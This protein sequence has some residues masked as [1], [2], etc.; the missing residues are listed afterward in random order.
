[1]KDFVCIVILIICGFI[2]FS[3]SFYTHPN[4]KLENLQEF[5]QIENSSSFFAGKGF[6]AGLNGDYK[7]AIEYFSKAIE[8]NPQDSISYHQ[9]GLCYYYENDYEHALKDFN[10]TINLNPNLTDAYGN[11]SLTKMQLGDYEGAIKDIEKVLKIA[12]NNP[13]SIKQKELILKNINKPN[14]I[15]ILR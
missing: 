15:K 7:S 10:K 14:A 6:T 3:V 1:M 9:R 12:P 8:L 11:R 13:K 4:N 2:W 5:E